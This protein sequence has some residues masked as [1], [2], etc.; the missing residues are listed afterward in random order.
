MRK[1]Y[2]HRVLSDLIL[3]VQLR[4][5]RRMVHLLNLAHY[6]LK[7][8]SSSWS[9]SSAN[10][11]GVLLGLPAPSWSF[12]NALNLYQNTSECIHM[13]GVC[14]CLS[15]GRSAC[16]PSSTQNLSH[17]RVNLTA[18]CVGSVASGVRRPFRQTLFL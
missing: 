2:I 9:S 4:S 13:W 8:L 11:C 14:L 10:S 12:Y 6:L 17:T 15:R 3:P 18:S 16:T 5:D 7:Q 1:R